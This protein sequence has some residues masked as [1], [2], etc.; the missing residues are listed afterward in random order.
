[1]RL[2]RATSRRILNWGMVLALVGAPASALDHES[3]WMRLLIAFVLG[4]GAMVFVH[5]M[6]I[7]GKADCEN[8]KKGMAHD[9]WYP[10]G[11]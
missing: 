9:L 10:D 7:Q 6:E 2:N 11:D 4:A 5:T 8:S 3:G 1:M